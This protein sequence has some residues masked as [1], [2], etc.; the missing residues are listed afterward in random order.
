MNPDNVINTDGLEKEYL[1]TIFL[2]PIHIDF[3]A[4]DE[5]LNEKTKQLVKEIQEALSGLEDL[6]IEVE[7]S[8]VDRQ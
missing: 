3:K 1:L 8:V 5:G 7:H 2:S 6:Y 4:S